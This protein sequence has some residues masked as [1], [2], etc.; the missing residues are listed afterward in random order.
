V[1][2][3]QITDDV[4]NDITRLPQFFET[5]GRV[6]DID[7]KRQKSLR[8]I[9][10][11]SPAER[12]QALRRVRENASL[13]AMVRASLAQR[14]SGYRFALERLVLMTP[15]PQAV[16]VERTLN[17]LQAQIAQYRRS[18]PNSWVREQSLAAV[19]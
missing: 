11:L 10:G 14:A 9:S 15:S 1:R 12:E 18:I 7:L 19:R 13:V 5:A 2:Y 17:Q 6:L 16:D 8:Y 3:A 4:R